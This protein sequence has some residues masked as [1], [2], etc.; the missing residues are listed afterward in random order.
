VERWTYE[1]DSE[2]IM[3]RGSRARK[4][5]DYTDSLTEKEWLKAIDENVDD[6]EDDEEEEIKS[7]RKGNRGK[8]RG[9]RNADDD[10]DPPIRRRKTIGPEEIKL[11]KK[12]KTIMNIVVKYTDA[13]SRIL[14]EPFMKL[15]SRHKL[16]DYYEVIKK[17]MDI[18]KI[19]AKIDDGKVLYLYLNKY[20]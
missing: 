17:P 10:D 2:E 14:S 15:P 9:K 13:D 8:K 12:M 20:F 19:M 1:E 6:F 16:P 7:N 4:E 18:K 11:R 3:G 5:V